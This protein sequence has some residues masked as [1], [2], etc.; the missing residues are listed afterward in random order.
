MS[1]VAAR[2]DAVRSTDMPGRFITFDIRACARSRFCFRLA[3][4]LAL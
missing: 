3:L 2:T 4:W 1:T